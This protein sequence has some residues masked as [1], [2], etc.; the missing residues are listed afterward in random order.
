MSHPSAE[1]FGTSVANVEPALDVLGP[2]WLLGGDQPDTLTC[3]SR[4]S[5]MVVAA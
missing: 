3:V 5:K 4:D 2:N 1:V